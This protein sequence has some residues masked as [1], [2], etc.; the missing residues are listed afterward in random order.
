MLEVDLMIEPQND[1]CYERKAKKRGCWDIILGI[2]L[3]ALTFTIGLLV[4]A[5]NAEAI[6][7][8]VSAIYVLIAVLALLLVINI[9]LI[10]CKN[11][12]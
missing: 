6:L 2:I 9:I 12:R 3:V 8:A 11:R 4:G 5:V 7:A 10:I 1:Y